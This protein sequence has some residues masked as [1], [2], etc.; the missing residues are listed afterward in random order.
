MHAGISC[1][2]ISDD[3]FQNGITQG[4]QWYSSSGMHNSVPVCC[5]EGFLQKG[6]TYTVV[7]VP[8]CFDEGFLQKGRAYTLFL[9]VVMRDSYRR[10]GH[11][12]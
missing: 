9:Y 12:L 6:R 10:A 5:D 1:P 4:N 7:S 2:N 8:V 3:Y 11:I